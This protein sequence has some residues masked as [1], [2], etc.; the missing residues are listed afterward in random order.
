M[1]PILYKDTE[2]AFDTNGIGILSD[3][4]SAQVVQELNGQYEL[5]MK[6]PVT[7]IHAESIA[8]R[9]IIMAKPDPVTD[10]QPFRIYRIN[11]VSKGTITAYARHIAYDTMGIPVAPF[12]AESLSDAFAAMKDSAAVD[13]PFIFTTDKSVAATMAPT[14]PKSMW[15]TL[16]GSDGSILDVYGGEYEFDR[17]SI[18]LH[19]RR[20]EDRGVSIRYG[21]NLKTLEQDRNCANVFTGVYPYWRSAEGDL[22]Q[23][24]EKVVHAEGTY[25]F[26]RIAT[27]DFSTY[28]EETPTVEQLRERTQKY[29]SDNDIGIPDIS[30]TVE[31]VRVE[32]TEEYKDKAPLERVLLGDSVTIIFPK[33]NVDTTSRVVKTVYD[34]IL[35]RY[36]NITLGK[37]KSNLADTIVAQKQELEKKSD[38]AIV[39]HVASKVSETEFEMT[40]LKQSAG[41]VSVEAADETGTLVTKINAGEWI[42][43]HT[44]SEGSVTSGFYFDFEKRRFVFDGTGVFRSED[45]KSY[46]TVEGK[47]FVLYS[48]AGDNGSFIDIA[49][50]GFTED[51][52]GYDYPYFLMGHADADAEDF[53]KIGLFKMFKNGLYVGNSAPRDSTGSFVGLVGASGMFIN[54]QEPKVYVV[55]G[56]ELSNAFEAVFA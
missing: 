22:A 38:Y 53:D 40:K 28:F 44:D 48:K 35:E 37:V 19:K 17:Y 54:T 45:G 8:D 52:E 26:T 27:V 23:L 9:C 31:F 12:I 55:D 11:P 20:G 15:K 46:I 47:E 42:A 18:Y 43:Q 25:D 39:Q 4:I 33:M 14:I 41:E 51:S 56:E 32:Q 7:G 3:A 10:P 30:L 6:Y 36:I 5:T 50:I 29:I 16:G 1:K 34:P 13:C 21:K 49:R 24:P 2:T